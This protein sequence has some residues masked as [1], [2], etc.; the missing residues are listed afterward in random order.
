ME[1]GEG[2]A[3]QGEDERRSEPQAADDL[4]RPPGSLRRQLIGALIGAAIA[5]VV[6]SIGRQLGWLG[7][8]AIQYLLWGGIIGGLVGGSDALAQAGKRLTRRDED[9]LNIL[10]SLIGM[11]AIMGVIFAL[12][13]V[14]NELVRGILVR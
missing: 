1:G 11:A 14:L 6:S 12:A 3:R 10:V 4:S 5:L 13:Y 8:D 2:M 7:G 9:W